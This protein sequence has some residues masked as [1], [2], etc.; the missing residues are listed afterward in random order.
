MP[1]KRKQN[2]HVS[3]L[4]DSYNPIGDVF[5]AAGDT[6]EAR[7]VALNI[8]DKLDPSIRDKATSSF[9]VYSREK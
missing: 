6:V 7:E 1:D 8:A 4:D 5:L 9:V 2:M 3:F